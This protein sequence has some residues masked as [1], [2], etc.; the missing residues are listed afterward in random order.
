MT[1]GHHGIDILRSSDV[2]VTGFNIQTPVLHD[3]STEWMNVGV[4]FANG[5]GTDVNM[6]HHR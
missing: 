4:V 5:K 3:L 6:D 2:L 1:Q